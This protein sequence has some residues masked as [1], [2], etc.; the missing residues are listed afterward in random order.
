MEKAN[1]L[2]ESQLGQLRARTRVEPEEHGPGSSESEFEFGLFAG[3]GFVLFHGVGILGLGK[4]AQNL[5]RRA[6]RNL[7]AR[8]LPPS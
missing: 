4:A 8:S 5:K 2:I 1:V 7:L 3:L 6:R